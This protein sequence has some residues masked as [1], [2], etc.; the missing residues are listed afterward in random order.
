MKKGR[1][2]LYIFYVSGLLGLAVFIISKNEYLMFKATERMYDEGDLYRF[3]K[4]RHFKVPT[5]VDEYSDEDITSPDLD[6]VSVFMIGDSFL[7]SSRGHKSLPTQLSEALGGYVHTVQAGDSTQY[8][9]PMYLF[10]KGHVRN[11]GPRV[12]ILERVERYIVDEFMDPF[13]EDPQLDSTITPPEGRSGWDVVERRW[14]TDAEKNYQILLTNS[15]V[16]APLI[17]LWNTACFSVLGRISEQTPVYSMTPPFLFY[18]EEVVRGKNTSFYYPHTD[19]LLAR[20]ADNIVLM[21]ET[22]KSRYNTD[23]LFMAI[24]NSYTLYHKFINNDAYDGFVPRLEDEL[25]KRGV[26]TVKLYQKFLDSNDVLYFPTDS[27]WNAKGV[28]IALNQIVER[29]HT[30]GRNRDNQ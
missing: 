22:M 20:I 9:N 11:S 28:A 2:L 26:K 4:V 18:E 13:D 7:G 3:A 10:K 19:S 8:F 25:E 21:S 27:H 24:P 14:F 29:L 17:E 15:R 1:F 6:S 23:L 5:P 30:L 16:T 12:L